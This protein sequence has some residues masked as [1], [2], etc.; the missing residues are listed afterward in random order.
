MWN[1]HAILK[2]TFILTITGLISRMIG[3]LFRIFLSHHFTEE[4]IGLYQLIF[5]LYG[6]CYSLST[7]G[8]EVAIS[9]SIAKYHAT[10]NLP[11]QKKIL[12]CGLG[13]SCLLSVCCTL[14]L[15]SQARFLSTH[16]LHDSRCTSLLIAI[17]Y[18]LPFA[19]VHSCICGYYYGLKQTKI[20]AF[21]TLF[22][23]VC[24]VA[25]VMSLYFLSIKM[26]KTPSILCAVL[27]MVIGEFCSMV[28]C[29]LSI[30]NTR[31]LNSGS[32]GILKKYRQQKGVQTS[33]LF[34]LLHLAVPLTTNRILL[35]VLQSVESISIPLCL[36][37]YG[38]T[39]SE[40]LSIYG[41]LTGMAMPCI[42]FPSAITNSLST[43]LLPSIAEITP[44]QH[45]SQLKQLC[46]KVIPSCLCLGFGCCIIF[47]LFGRL[48]GNLLFHST[49]AGDFLLV[50][51]WICPFLYTNSTLMS[52]LNGLGKPTLSFLINTCGLSLR[53]L[54]IYYGIPVMGMMGYLFGLLASQLLITF[55]GILALVMHLRHS[56]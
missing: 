38:Y 7:A 6:L 27:G 31:I 34:E 32:K 14:F 40:A 22:E 52:I 51:A 4:Q 28:Y 2:G 48:L 53:I 44:S 37:Q 16:F 36:R 1:K 8:I 42:L 19:S 11:A 55:L 5:P 21:S 30:K 56:V 9:R 13:L 41:V 50:L 17:S 26:Q 10:K 46:Q 49:L 47:V 43:M 23:Q 15:Q 39:T 54:S 35:N 18:A 29:V 25:G 12:S 3:F 20:P 33:A 24:R 45:G